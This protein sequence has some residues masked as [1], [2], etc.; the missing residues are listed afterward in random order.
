MIIV[1]TTPSQ[2]FTV[3][4]LTAL[5]GRVRAVSY[6]AAFAAPALP[7]ATYVFTDFDRLLP[8]GMEAV[9]GLHRRIAAAGGRTIND[10]GR[11]VGRLA[12]LRALHRAGINPFTAWP[13]VPCPEPD[14]WPVFLRRQRGHRGPLSGLIHDPVTLQAAIDDALASGT[15][16]DDLIVV[17]YCA[18]PTEDG[19]FRRLAV[20]R[21]GDVYVAD[22]CVHERHWVAKIGT[23]GIT[24]PGAHEEELRIVR[25][26]PWSAAAAAV[27]ELAGVEYGRVDFGLVGGRP[28]FYEVN[29]NP[30]VRFD[31]DVDAPE[32]LEAG[33]TVRR[34]FLAALDRLDG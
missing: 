6:A 9:I 19:L 18:E 23:P 17:A 27:F 33:Q 11:F 24:G 10:P 1:L 14:R 2:T 13:A 12:L 8:E 5:D 15:V 34:R 30:H 26:S 7:R 20:Y 29:T 3:Q 28:C 22:G 21:I 31:F 4:A 32:R 16:P 25:D